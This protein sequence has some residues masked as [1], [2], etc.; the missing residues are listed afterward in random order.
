[1]KMEKLRIVWS[2]GIETGRLVHLNKV[3]SDLMYNILFCAGFA[4]ERYSLQ[5]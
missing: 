2:C 3:F 5:F 4:L 1:M